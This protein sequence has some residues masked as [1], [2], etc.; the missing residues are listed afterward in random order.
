MVNRKINFIN[1]TQR[2]TAEVV[3]ADAVCE[4]RRVQKRLSSNQ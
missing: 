2:T 4:I 1:N 3:F